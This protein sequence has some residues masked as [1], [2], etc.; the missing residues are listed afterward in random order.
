MKQKAKKTFISKIK[1]EKRN[2]DLSLLNDITNN[3]Y[4]NTN[5][6]NNNKEKIKGKKE[7]HSSSDLITKN[8][9]KPKHKN[10]NKKKIKYDSIVFKMIQCRN[11]KKW[12]LNYVFC[13]SEFLTFE[14]NL[15]IRIVCKLFNDGIIMRYRFLEEN[16]LFSMD[17][18]I[19]E[20]IRKEYKINNKK[21]DIKLFNELVEGTDKTKITKKEKEFNAIIL[22]KRPSGNFSKKQLLINMINNKDFISIKSRIKSGEISIPRNLCV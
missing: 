18:K 19:H 9:S 5:N 2:T 20:K 16:I 22:N 15:S 17:N 10:K 3:I 11:N 6:N 14:E 1:G 21:K 7:G 4:N 8:K 12:K 13:V